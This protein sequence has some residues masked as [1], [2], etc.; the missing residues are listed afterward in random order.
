MRLPGPLFELWSFSS[1]EHSPSPYSTMSS[2]FGGPRLRFCQDSTPARTPLCAPRPSLPSVTPLGPSASPSTSP[3]G[4]T[5]VPHLPISA[6]QIQG[7]PITPGP[8]LCTSQ[9][10]SVTHLAPSLY[11]TP[12]PGP[13]SAA[14]LGSHVSRPL[15]PLWSPPASSRSVA[16]YTHALPSLSI[17]IRGS[18]PKPIATMTPR[19]SHPGTPLCPILGTFPASSPLGPSR[20]PL[21]TPCRH[22]E[23][24][25]MTPYAPPL[26]PP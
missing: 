8:S 5:I 25:P 3:Q 1:P 9:D 26:L 24:H 15:G 13:S 7:L 22:P 19:L 12:S 10:P 4:L 16:P 23:R 2:P 14:P 20:T 17:S 6:L 21:A 11:D 18:P